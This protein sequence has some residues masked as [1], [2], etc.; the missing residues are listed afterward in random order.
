M[1]PTVR[2]GDT[3]VFSDTY[4]T[5]A[6][7]LMS[8]VGQVLVK[9]TRELDSDLMSALASRPQSFEFAQ[10]VRLLWLAACRDA[11]ARN[12]APVPDL[13]ETVRFRANASLAFPASAVHSSR[14]IS[15]DRDDSHVRLLRRSIA[16]L[17]ADFKH[18]H[19]RDTH[20]HISG[21]S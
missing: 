16:D 19:C 21:H 20:H 17:G 5:F 6:A 13:D 2:V 9:I 10:I 12:N 8:D 14:L 3:L 11:I 18:L 7:G 15:P 1:I 4:A